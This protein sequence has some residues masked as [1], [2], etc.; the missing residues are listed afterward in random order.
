MTPG[1]LP[2]DELVPSS[3]EKALYQVRSVI[4]RIQRVKVLDLENR[5]EK[6]LDDAELRMQVAS[7]QLRV[8][9]HGVDREEVLHDRSEE[10]DRATQEALQ[11]LQAILNLARQYEVTFRRAY[12]MLVKEVLPEQG[13][14]ALKPLS[15]SQAYRLWE[16]E[17]NGMPVRM[18][19][20]TKGN[21]EPRYGPEVYDYIKEQAEELLLQTK[22]RWTLR[23]LTERINRKRAANPC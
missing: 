18:A 17:R 16:R 11:F 13:D 9:R 21:R 14:L 6:L 22:S 4:P 10:E 1:F 15:L 20:A 2:G 3:S 12:A 19:N 8:W 7:G 5:D 23:T